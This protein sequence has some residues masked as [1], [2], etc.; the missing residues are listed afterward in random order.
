M[1]SGL[2]HISYKMQ[3]R[4]P[5]RLFDLTPVYVRGPLRLSDLTPVYVR[6]PLRLFDLAPVY[7]NTRNKSSH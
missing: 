2:T 6:G 4:G 7:V 1:Q 5:L 3:D